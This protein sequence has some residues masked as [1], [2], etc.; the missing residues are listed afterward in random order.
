MRTVH[1]VGHAVERAFRPAG[2]TVLQANGRAADQTVFHV[3]FHVVPRHVS[4]GVALS[5]P[6]QEPPLEKLMQHASQIK[7]ML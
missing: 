7:K 6:R 5:W 4:D 1:R 2:L 3:H